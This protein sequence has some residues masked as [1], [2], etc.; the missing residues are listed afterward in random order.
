MIVRRLELGEMDAAAR[1]HRAAFNQALPS[2][3]LTRRKTFMS[4]PL[5]ITVATLI[6]HPTATLMLDS[7]G[8]GTT[9][10][11]LGCAGCTRALCW[12]SLAFLDIFD[13]FRLPL[14]PVL[15]LTWPLRALAAPGAADIRW[16]HE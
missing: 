7:S 4:R 10:Q 6:S 13:P 14:P 5:R 11:W 8:A 16:R 15:R 1:I 9:T 12:W 3:A 2:L